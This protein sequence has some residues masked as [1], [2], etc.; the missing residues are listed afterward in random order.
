MLGLSACAQPEL[1]RDHFYRLDVP[2]PEKT[3]STPVINGVVEIGRFSAYG[4]V[5]KRPIVYSVKGLPLEL[6]DYNYHFWTAPPPIMLRDQLVEYLRAVGAAK[7]VVTPEMRI[8]PDHVL[9]VK[10][11]RLEKITGTPPMVAVELEMM[12]RKVGGRKPEFMG[13]YNVEL[14]AADNTVSAAVQAVNQAIGQIYA[15][16]ANDLKS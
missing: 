9:A 4:L 8:P 1:P 14:E 10:I 16:F 13:T 7:T 6:R 11:K 3:F 2:A 12:L 5:A 15:K